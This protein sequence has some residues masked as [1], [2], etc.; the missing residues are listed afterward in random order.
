MLKILSVDFPFLDE[1]DQA[2]TR[3]GVA[4]TKPLSKYNIIIVAYITSHLDD[5]L[6]TDIVLH[7]N[8][9]G[10]RNT[11][12]TKSSCIKLHK[13]ASVVMG[14]VHGELGMLPE[15]YEIKVKEKLRQLFVL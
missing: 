11:G 7:L 13:L 9:E 3:P 12:L 14:R 2:K 8:E 5:V 1:P 15:E 4:L 10:Y 6:P